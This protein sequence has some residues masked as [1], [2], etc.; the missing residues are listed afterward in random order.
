MACNRF[1]F[2]LKILGDIETSLLRVEVGKYAIE[3]PVF[4]SGLARSGTT[5]LLTMLEELPEGS[6]EH[7]LRK[8][9]LKRFGEVEEIA[10]L[11][12]FLSSPAADFFTGQVFSPNGGLV[13]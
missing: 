11:V 13:I 9:P 10:A 7:I 5:I 6:S 2:M 4:I 8:T 12:G 3:S 1:A